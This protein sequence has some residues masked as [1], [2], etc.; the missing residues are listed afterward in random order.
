M[1]DDAGL[2]PRLRNAREQRGLSQQAVSEALGLPRTA[3]TN[4]ET[5]NRSLST[6]ELMKLAKLYDRPVASFLEDEKATADDA[7]VVFLRAFQ[8]ASN[9]L[10]FRDAIDYVLTL[11]REGAVLRALLDQPIEEP[12]PDYAV[13]VRSAGDAIR[14]GDYVAQEERRRLGLGDAPIGN[15]A[16]LIGGQGI[17]VAACKLPDDMSGLFTHDR[18]SGLSIIVN[19]S[20]KHAAVRRR[21]SYVHEYGHAL[22]DRAEPYRLTQRINADEMVEKRAN[23]FAAS[24]LMPKGGIENQ[25]R[26]LDKGR[27]SRQ[28]QIV[29]DVAGDAPSEAEIRPPTGSQTITWQDVG[30]IAWHFGVSYESVVWRLRNLNHLGP[31]ETTTLLAQKD[32]RLRFEDIL[33]INVTEFLPLPDD[34]GQ[35]LRNQVVGLAIE[36]FRREEISQGRLRELAVE[37]GIQASDLIELAESARAD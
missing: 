26:Q 20:S 37:L 11:C 21:F 36:A 27:P 28:A 22:F 29:Y 12:L 18:R 32:K 24:F 35:E 15:I 30:S 6:T 23:A 13:R 2:G 1:T 31:T 8:Q 10:E 4:I 17:W 5:G 7:S 33:K 14:Q 25:L 3:V 9:G 19:S 16:S 34:R